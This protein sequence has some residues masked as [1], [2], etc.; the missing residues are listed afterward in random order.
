MNLVEE[1]RELASLSGEILGRAL[2]ELTVKEV[3]R[4][5]RE[6]MHVGTLRTIHDRVTAES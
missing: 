6:F 4:D 2:V 3:R 1:G 5:G